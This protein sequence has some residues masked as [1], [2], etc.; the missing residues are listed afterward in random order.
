MVHN[1][2]EILFVALWGK[3]WVSHF[4][5]AWMIN[6]FKN[7]KLPV[8]I[9]FVLINLFNSDSFKSFLVPSLEDCSKGSITDFS[10]KGVP[11]FANHLSTG[12]YSINGSINSFF[13]RFIL[14]DLLSC[15]FLTFIKSFAIFWFSSHFSSNW[16]LAHGYEL[17]FNRLAFLIFRV[18]VNILRP[19]N[20]IDHVEIAFEMRVFIFDF[21]MV[22]G[23]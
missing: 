20:A 8:F 22:F 13:D 17:D 7:F 18:S 12:W 5:D 21:G 4:K 19:I 23:S 14:E 16:V 15:I 9:L 6:D 2:V 11:I 1:Y 10:V 3:E